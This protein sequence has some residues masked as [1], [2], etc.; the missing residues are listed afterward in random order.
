MLNWLFL[1]ISLELVDQIFDVML[2]G[3][4]LDN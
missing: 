3:M 1:S 2:C 4:Y